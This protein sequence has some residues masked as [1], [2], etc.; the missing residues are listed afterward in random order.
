MGTY[1]FEGHVPADLVNK[2]LREKPANARGLAVPGMPMGSP[3]MEM[4]GHKD[5]Y[6]VVLFDRAGKTKVYAK[7]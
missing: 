2:L 3:G 1:V 7:R 6:D 4:G 5:P